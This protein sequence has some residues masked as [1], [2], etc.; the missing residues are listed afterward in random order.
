MKDCVYIELTVQSSTFCNG[1]G[2]VITCPQYIRC[3][4][5][6]GYTCYDRS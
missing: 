3:D 4:A 2:T 1:D 6:R 5:L